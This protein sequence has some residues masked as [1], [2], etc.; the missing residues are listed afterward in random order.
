M[1]IGVVQSRYGSV[2]NSSVPTLSFTANPASANLLLV[3]NS[4]NSTVTSITSITDTPGNVY[5]SHAPVALASDVAIDAWRATNT[6]TT[7]DTISWHMSATAA[8]RMVIVEISGH[9]TTT[10]SDGNNTTFLTGSSGQINGAP[11]NTNSPT[12]LVIGMWRVPGASTWASGAT[13]ALLGTPL[14]G[15]GGSLAA[16]QRIVS[17]TAA[18]TPHIF[19]QRG[20][21]AAGQAAA[22]TM[23][24]QESSG[25]ALAVNSTMTGSGVLAAALRVTTPI[26][27]ITMTGEG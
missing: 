4:I 13:W 14:F 20:A 18:Y 8:N 12:D 21:T 16:V 17:A 1:P 11:L 23:A 25:G 6:L 15:A 2:G 5:S 19:N 3:A 22:L 9:N 7:A 26:P 27:G 24:F 10:L